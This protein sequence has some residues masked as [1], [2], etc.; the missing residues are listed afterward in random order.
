MNVLLTSAT[1]YIGRAVTRALQANGH[2]VVGIAR[3]TAS[4]QRLELA[5]V[6][7][8]RGDLTKVN[9]LRQA[10]EQ[11]DAGYQAIAPSIC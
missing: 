10:T 7:P 5:G 11:V 3:S 9:S 4:A 8:H 6:R 1:G 2:Q